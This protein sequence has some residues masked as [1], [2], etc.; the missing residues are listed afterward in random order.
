VEAIK[1]W[2]VG[3]LGASAIACAF[4]FWFWLKK[5]MSTAVKV[6]TTQIE[7]NLVKDV[8]KEV[9]D[10]KDIHNRLDTDPSYAARL[11]KKYSRD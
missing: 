1:L 6:E 10:V 4:A 9:K 7:N 5:L 8:L 11:R 2:I 3:G